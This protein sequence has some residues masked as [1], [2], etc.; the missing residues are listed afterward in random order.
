VPGTADLY[1]PAFRDFNGAIR[2]AAS[3]LIGMSLFDDM[4]HSQ[5]RKLWLWGS[6]SP[7]TRTPYLY[8][9]RTGMSVHVVRDDVPFEFELARLD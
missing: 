2:S 7:T 1:R 5:P 3:G 8:P 6:E 9:L 4:P